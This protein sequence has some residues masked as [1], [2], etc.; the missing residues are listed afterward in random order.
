M[1]P[2]NI[3]L[4]AVI[5]IASLMLSGCKEKKRHQTVNPESWVVTGFVFKN[6]TSEGDIQDVESR[7]IRT[8]KALNEL[9]G[10]EE[11]TQHADLYTRYYAS[12]Y[13][14]LVG[15]FPSSSSFTK[16]FKRKNRSLSLII[17][18]HSGKE[19]LDI[20][21]ESLLLSRSET[22]PGDAPINSF[23]DNG[24][25]GNGYVA[26]LLDSGT[27]SDHPAFLNKN[28]TIL[29]SDQSNDKS[30]NWLMRREWLK[31]EGSRHLR[32]A[33]GTAVAGALAGNP[34]IGP[35][36][37]IAKDADII[38]GYAGSAEDALTPEG[39]GEM[40]N[41]IKD[42]KSANLTKA[43]LTYLKHYNI[44]SLNYSFGH[45]RILMPAKSGV[46]SQWQTWSFWARYFDA[47]SFENDFLFAKSAGNDGSKYPNKEQ[48][49]K[50]QP[51]S[52]SMPGDNYNGLTVANVDTTLSGGPTEKTTD[53]AKHSVRSTSSR[54]PTTDGRR[55]PDI[56][57]PG[58][59][60]RT[61]APDPDAYTY[62][63]PYK[64]RFTAKKYKEYDPATIT[65]ISSGTSLASPHVA[66]AAVLVRQAL[67]ETR[68]SQYKKF[69]P[70]VKAVLINHSDNHSQHVLKEDLPQY[71]DSNGHWCPS[72]G[73][74]YMDMTQAYKEYQN[75]KQFE[76]NSG[77]QTKSYRIV[78]PVPNFKATLVWEH[79]NFD[80]ASKLLAVDMTL[81]NDNNKQAIQSDRGKG[82]HNVLQ[83]QTKEQTDLCLE[84]EAKNMLEF[85]VDTLS[86]ASNTELIPVSSCR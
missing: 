4:L 40:A 10:L 25:T 56:A 72:R 81:Y 38:S 35:H 68:D 6:G 51:Y 32:S 3:S 54:G 76:L 13:T 82:L 9:K 49:K 63:G 66:G 2:K 47:V 86:L 52:L 34:S 36:K 79:Q 11:Y 41:I 14:F 53:R 24:I 7:L 16:D 80:S 78:N 27:D 46:M 44:V 85:S 28:V 1:K 45:G 15:P 58:H 55:K 74:G 60:T 20:N 48:S 26:A 12:G 43:T 50:P 57:A 5:L 18:I 21:V 42:L 71:C 75:A 62:Q 29:G 64:H 23:W 61:A 84:I 19:E 31:T 59:Q 69:S 37:G 30:Y 77:S 65:R 33:H 22:Q 8:A 17:P 70:I 39:D 83:V 67:E 73:W